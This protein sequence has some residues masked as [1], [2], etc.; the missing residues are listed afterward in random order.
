MLLLYSRL[1]S[2]PS[3]HNY[4]L[5]CIH[6]PTICTHTSSPTSLCMLVP[7]NTELIFYLTP[8]ICF[9]DRK[10]SSPAGRDVLPLIPCLVLPFI[11]CGEGG[12]SLHPV[13]GGDVLPLISCGV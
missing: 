6:Q 7:N 13:R 5:V 11:L 1:L 3:V 4:T 10:Y 9:N 2:Y 12:S 8:Y